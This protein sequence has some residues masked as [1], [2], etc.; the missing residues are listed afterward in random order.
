MEDSSVLGQ[1]QGPELR[2]PGGSGKGRSRPGTGK[3]SS[4]QA[5]AMR[6]EQEKPAQE[7]GSVM[8][9]RTRMLVP[10]RRR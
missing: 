9:A 2:G 10:Q 4:E 5:S 1:V 6:L 7:L 8:M 3:R